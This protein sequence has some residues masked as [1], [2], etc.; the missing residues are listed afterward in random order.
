MSYPKVRDEII[1]SYIEVIEENIGRENIDY[2]SATATAAIP[3]GSW[4]AD[5]L[6]LPMVFVRPS[7]KM[8]GKGSK[9]EGFLKKGSRLVIIED[10]ISTA[11]SVKGN[12][13]S[14]RELGGY[15]KYC[16]ATTTYQTTLSEKNLQENEIEL[17]ALTTGKIIIEQAFKKGLLNKEQKESV[18]LWFLD[19][20]SWAA[21]MGIN[22]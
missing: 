7:T 4:I 14:I 12:A 21:K 20:P 17:I 22:E 15:T 5:R 16:I 1:T 2:I 9:V 18:D 3:Q 13:L 19:P 6:H 8:H 10:H 11:E